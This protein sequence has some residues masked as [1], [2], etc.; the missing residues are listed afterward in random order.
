MIDY[1]KKYEVGFMIGTQSSSNIPVRLWNEPPQ[2]L[3][4]KEEPE[5]MVIFGNFVLLKVDLSSAVV[6]QQKNDNR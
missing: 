5:K 4:F 6:I 2:I 3:T 1:L